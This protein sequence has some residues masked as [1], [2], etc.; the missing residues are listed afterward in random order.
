MK[1]LKEFKEFALRGNVMDMAIGIVIGA[2]FGA[3]VSSL[4]NDIL[5]PP[6]GMVLGSVDFTNLF[7]S[8]DGQQYASLAAAQEAGAPTINYGLFINTIINFVI[9][10]FVIF[11]LIRQINRLQRQP[12]ETPTEPT[13][14]ECPYCVSEIPIK[15]TRCPQC[16]SDL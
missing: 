2:A 9:I 16:T 7:V 10:A 5:M 12:E 15:A 14:K 1:M 3:I 8:L 13:T 11:L 6:I 4:V